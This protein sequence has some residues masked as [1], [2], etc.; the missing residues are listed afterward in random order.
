MH[1]RLR[2]GPVGRLLALIV[3]AQEED[4]ELCVLA[5]D[6]ELLAPGLAQA[7]V[8][9]AASH[10][11]EVYPAAS[12]LRCGATEAQQQTRFCKL[13]KKVLLLAGRAA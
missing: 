11:E 10:S 13:R 8:A 1:Q 5:Q 3:P 9:F 4:Q 7:A 12:L 2:W 6:V